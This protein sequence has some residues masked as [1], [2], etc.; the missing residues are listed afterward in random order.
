MRNRFS[1]GFPALTRY[2]LAELQPDLMPFMVSRT[3]AQ[4]ASIKQDVYE[5]EEIPEYCLSLH[6]NK[7]IQD[8][9]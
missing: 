3:P 9:C 6:F 5:I 8:L 2:P 1:H 4:E 7:V